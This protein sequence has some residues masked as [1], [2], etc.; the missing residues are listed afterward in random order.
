[1]SEQADDE[2]LLR[3]KNGGEFLANRENTTLYTFIGRLATRNHVFLEKEREEDIRRG[4]YIF[5]HSKIYH[6]L[7]SFIAEYDYPMELNK[8]RVPPGDEEAF[9]QSLEYITPD[10]LGDFVPDDWK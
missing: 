2:L 7:V 4:S 9:Q 6:E 8:T 10:D 5:A 1:M 3:F